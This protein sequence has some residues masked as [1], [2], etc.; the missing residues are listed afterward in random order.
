[1]ID[2]TDSRSLRELERLDSP[3]GVGQASDCPGDFRKV[4]SLRSMQGSLR[5]L[6]HGVGRRY[7]G[8]FLG[9]IVFV[10]GTSVVTE[11][12]CAKMGSSVLRRTDARK[13][14]VSARSRRSRS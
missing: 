2:G 9:E 6:G 14:S 3:Y 8:I 5:P 1:M 4:W 11:C 7:R 12:R 13:N 10:A